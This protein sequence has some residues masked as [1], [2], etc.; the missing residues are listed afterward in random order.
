MNKRWLYGK[1]V[2]SGKSEQLPNPPESP[3]FSLYRG[4]DEIPLRD[5]IEYL[6]DGNIIKL[7]KSGIPPDYL[8]LHERWLEI[9]ID[10]NDS[11]GTSEIKLILTVS[12]EIAVLEYKL[13]MIH[14]AIAVMEHNYD[15]TLADFLNSICV[16]K[17]QFK[18]D[19]IKELKSC[20]NRS[21]SFKISLDLKRAQYAGILEKQ[22]ASEGEKPT[23]KFFIGVLILLS[24]H[25]KYAITDSIT[26]AE[27]CERVKQYNQYC[28]QLKKAK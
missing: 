21:K 5:F 10:Y 16:T 8:S 17:Y 26:V 28:E 11:M 6:I 25:A 2:V 14:A 9:L 18:E 23:R 13:K 22:N 3:A 27:Y 1:R 4:I 12:K 19:K 24:N 7:V 15:Q 20:L